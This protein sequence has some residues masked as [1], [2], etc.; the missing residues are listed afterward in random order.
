MKRPL[1]C[2]IAL[3]LGLTGC[4][5]GAAPKKIALEGR[6]LALGPPSANSGVF[7]MFRLAKYEVVR[8]CKGKYL[9]SEIVVDH[10]VLDGKEFDGIDVG[11]TL[12]ITV[13]QEKKISTRFNAPG[14]R[15]PSEKPN[16][17]FVAGAPAR[18][19]PAECSQ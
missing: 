14:I 10:L 18:K 4:E 12:W 3:T 16:S 5:L 11:E 7:A 2:F 9:G 15:E 19:M 1:I 6:L 17:Y 8:V 13:K